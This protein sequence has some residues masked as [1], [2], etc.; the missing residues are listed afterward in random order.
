M[1]LK[2]RRPKKGN[3]RFLHKKERT[4]KRKEGDARRRS[5][6]SK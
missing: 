6:D 4:A 5:V 2:K 1:E 3:V